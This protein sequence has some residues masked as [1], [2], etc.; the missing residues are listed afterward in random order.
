MEISYYYNDGIFLHP[1]VCD[2]HRDL[3]LHG[4]YALFLI[5][6]LRYHCQK[7]VSTFLFIATFVCVHTTIH[8]K[9]RL[10]AGENLVIKPYDSCGRAIQDETGLI[11]FKEPI[12]K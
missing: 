10:H 5:I 7:K 4:R 9:S 8:V 1:F 2:N 6:V 11:L 12:N 3:T